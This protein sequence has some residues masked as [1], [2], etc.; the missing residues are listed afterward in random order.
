MDRQKVY[1]KYDKCNETYS[2]SP[3]AISLS[4]SNNSD[5]K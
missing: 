4:R 1:G 5:S 2:T 3:K